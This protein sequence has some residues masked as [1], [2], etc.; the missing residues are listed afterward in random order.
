MLTW[1]VYYENINHKKIETFNVFDHGRFLEDCRKVAKKYGKDRA[2]FS[3]QLRKELLYYFWCKAE[4][5][6]VIC[7]LFQVKDFDG[8]KVD[9]YSQ[10]M[11]N[12]DI[13]VDYVFTHQK[14]LMKDRRG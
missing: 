7:P 5:E 1:N 3:E 4:F 14:E 2:A 13:F 12:W 10:V 9:I 8:E 11:L 6:V